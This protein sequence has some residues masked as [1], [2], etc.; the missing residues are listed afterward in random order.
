MRVINAVKIAIGNFKLVFKNLLYRTII[1]AVLA[2]AAGFIL[3][4]S[5]APFV[6]KLAPVMNDLWGVFK[7]LLQNNA[8]QQSSNLSA[9][10]RVFMEYLSENVG[11]IVLTGIICVL[12]LCFY[13]FLAGVGDGTLLILVDGHMSSLSHRKYLGVMFENLKRI[14]RYQLLDAVVAILYYAVVFTLE[15][16]LLRYVAG[17]MPPL[18]IFLGVCMLTFAMAFYSTCMSQVMTNVI[19][20]NMKAKD[21]FKKGLALGKER[22]WKMYAAYLS[23]IILYM[24][25]ALSM[26]VF[27]FGVG[28]VLLASFFA[29]LMATIKLVDYYSV[30]IKKYFIDYDNIIVPKELRE[31]DERLLNKVDI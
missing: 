22:F 6:E 30:N 10:F 5:L 19:L 17:I 2:T 9:D 16:L 18:V 15:F 7:T 13:R 31:N 24:Y 11:N 12:I 21:A 27:T 8:T 4:I 20:E 3:K 1:F 28:T 23:V 25:F 29:L 14:V 26:A